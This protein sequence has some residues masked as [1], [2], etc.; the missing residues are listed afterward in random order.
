VVLKAMLVPLADPLQFSLAMRLMLALP[1]V[2]VV[3]S[4]P[5]P[6]R[7]SRLPL[8]VAVG[9][10]MEPLVLLPLRLEATAPKESRR[11]ELGSTVPL[12]WRLAAGVVVPMASRLLVSSKKKLAL[13]WEYTPLAPAKTMLP[14]VK[15]VAVPVPPLATGT[16]A[17]VPN[18]PPAVLV[19]IP[20]VERPEKVMVP[21][22]V[23]PVAAAMAPVVLT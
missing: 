17:V 1:P 8:V 11:I 23:I 19:T 20:A 4:C 2:L 22:L 15:A 12:M 6:V 5:E 14:V 3:P 16:E 21:E 13:S 10:P 18:T 7:M 9:E